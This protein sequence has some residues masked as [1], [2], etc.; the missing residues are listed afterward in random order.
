ME[1]LS[2][3]QSSMSAM[4]SELESWFGVDL[5]FPQVLLV[6]AVLL[7]FSVLFGLF[8]KVTGPL[9]TAL[10]L[11]LLIVVVALAIWVFMHT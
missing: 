4:W 8:R 5:A 11:L 7:A 10:K 3:I 9:M 6:I 2:F 1:I